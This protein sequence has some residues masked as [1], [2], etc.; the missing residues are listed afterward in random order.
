MVNT[1]N[2]A[3]DDSNF[4]QWKADLNKKIAGIKQSS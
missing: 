3:P 1:S 4:D 2:Q